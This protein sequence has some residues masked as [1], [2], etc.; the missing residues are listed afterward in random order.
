MG[1]R[2]PAADG[3]Q[4]CFLGSGHQPLLTDSWSWSEP[5]VMASQPGKPVVGWGLRRRGLAPGGKGEEDL[6]LTCSVWQSK[7]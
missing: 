4:W 7:Q 3:Q 5:R 2:R 6:G 1:A